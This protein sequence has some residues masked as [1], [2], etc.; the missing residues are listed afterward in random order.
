[1]QSPL[2]VM[3]DSCSYH[4]FRRRIAGS[5]DLDRYAELLA[6]SRDHYPRR[7]YL[8]GNDVLVT[9]RSRGTLT[10]GFAPL[11]I[12]LLSLSLGYATTGS[13]LASSQPETKGTADIVSRVPGLETQVEIMMDEDTPQARSAKAA[14]IAGFTASQRGSS[15]GTVGTAAVPPPEQEYAYIYCDRV[16]VFTD[17]SGT[18]SLQKRC[19]E[20]YAPWGY[21]LDPYW[22]AR[23]VSPVTESGL[24]WWNQS[25]GAKLGQNSPHVAPADYA[26]HGTM[27][28][29][30]KGWYVKYRDTF[31]FR[32]PE[33][34][35]KIT[36]FGYLYFA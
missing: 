6:G 19:G 29:V 1:M 31:T 7:S 16:Y 28:P 27:N 4:P 3:S 2:Q 17:Q 15:E 12:L 34:T 18:F 8:R 25:T 21:V 23:A 14:L 24:E 22:Q 13:A 33:G 36:I 32:I 9:I 26:F 10:R 20:P 30:K 5:R 35:V 11:L